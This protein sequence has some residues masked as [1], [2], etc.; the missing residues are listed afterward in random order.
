MNKYDKLYKSYVEQAEAISAAA[1]VEDRE[2]TSDELDKIN[3]LLANADEAKEKADAVRSMEAHTDILN[4]PTPQVEPASVSRPVISGVKPAIEDDPKRGF[5]SLGDFAMS[6]VNAANPSVPGV[7]NRLLIGSAATGMNQTTGADGGFDVPP[8][9]NTAIWDGLNEQ[10]DNLLAMTDQYVLE[11]TESLTLNAN[12]ETSRVGGSRYGGIDHTW[13][14][15]EADQIPNS[16]P[17]VRQIS[18]TPNELAV[19]VFATEK[20]LRN[21]TAMEQYLTRAS[22]DEIGF[23]TSNV[24]FNGTGAGQPTGLIGHGGTVNVASVTA[25]VDGI[26]YTDVRNMYSRCHAR[27]RRGA[28]WFINQDLEPFLMGMEDGNGN[29][30]YL[31]AG[32]VAGAPFATLLGKPVMPLEYCQTAGTSGDIVFGNLDYYATALRSYGLQTASSIHLRFDFA[33]KAFRFIFEVDGRPWLT[34]PLTPANGTNTLSPFVTL[35]TRV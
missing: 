9:F 6:V 26:S 34:A 7:D 2:I 31:P 25:L 27:A 16:K 14:A 24:I 32:N 23:V 3:S 19:M 18:L 5:N 4:T 22:V 11:N 33:E 8:E 35:A 1:E 12:A 13:L 30:V 20:L 29:A 21:G 17:T 28:A 10:P 15:A